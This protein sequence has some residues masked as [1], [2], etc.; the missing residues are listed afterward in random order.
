MHMKKLFLVLVSFMV[1]RCGTD[2]YLCDRC[3]SDADYYAENPDLCW[4]ECGSF[5]GGCGE[6]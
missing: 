1:I 4:E 6:D 2:T 3:C 5:Y